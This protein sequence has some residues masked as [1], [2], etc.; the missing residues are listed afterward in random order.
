MRCDWFITTEHHDEGHLRHNHYRITMGHK[1]GTLWRE[2]HLPLL[3]KEKISKNVL[4]CL[5]EGFVSQVDIYPKAEELHFGLEHRKDYA[6]LYKDNDGSRAVIDVGKLME[7]RKATNSSDFT[8]QM[9]FK[10]SRVSFRH[11]KEKS[12]ESVVK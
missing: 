7:K 10:A 9:I 2:Y 6:G 11:E 1:K 3:R 4:F 12:G 5:F 8:K